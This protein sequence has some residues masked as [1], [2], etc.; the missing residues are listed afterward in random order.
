MNKANILDM[1]VIIMQNLVFESQIIFDK[2]GPQISIL[3]NYKVDLSI[4]NF[5]DGTLWSNSR[6]KALNMLKIQQRYFYPINIEK[7]KFYSERAPV[8]FI[9]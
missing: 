3:N 9:Y 7:I 5:Y 6:F 4:Q 2:F 1:S 8:I